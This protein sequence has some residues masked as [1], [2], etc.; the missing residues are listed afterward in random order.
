MKTAP[1]RKFE[2]S[3]TAKEP[4][5]R[6]WNR[7]LMSSMRT[8]YTGPRAK[9]PSSAGKSEMSSLIKLGI[10]TAGSSKS[11]STKAAAERTPVTAIARAVAEDFLAPAGLF[12]SIVVSD[13]TVSFLLVNTRISQ[14]RQ[15]QHL[16]PKKRPAE[17]ILQ[18]SD[19]EFKAAA[20]AA[21]QFCALKF[22]SSIQTLLLV[23][24]LQRISRLCR[25]ADFTASGELPPAPKN[26]QV[27]SL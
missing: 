2:S 21:S 20:F 4:E 25:V 7:F 15:P 10:S 6:Q 23:P 24:Y 1:S 13:I 18:G 19:I 8:P 5:N 12:F 26:T 27:F 22:S 3:P 14:R 11:C 9:A 17:R 16:S